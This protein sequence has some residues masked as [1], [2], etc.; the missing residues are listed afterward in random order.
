MLPG[1]IL[2]INVAVVFKQ[3]HMAFCFIHA[4]S[5]SANCSDMDAI[6]Y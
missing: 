2:S 4:L 3:V 5:V 6:Q 1:C